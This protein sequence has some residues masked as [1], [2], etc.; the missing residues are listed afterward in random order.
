MTSEEAQQQTVTLPVSRPEASDQSL[1]GSQAAASAG[2]ADSFLSKIVKVA[3][4]P[5]EQASGVKGDVEPHRYPSPVQEVFLCA[6]Q[7]NMTAG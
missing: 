2:T 5:F 4:S 6:A 3:F 7:Q 1:Q